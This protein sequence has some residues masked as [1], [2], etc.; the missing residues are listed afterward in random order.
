MLMFK[1]YWKDIPGFEN[2]YQASNLGR[3]KSLSKT[4]KTGRGY[5]RTVPDR[6]MKC[7]KLTP[8]GYMRVR[9]DKI[10]Y[11]L[12]RL[13]AITF[14]GAPLP[15]SDR[16]Q[17][18]HINGDKTDNRVENLEWVTNQENRDHAV[19][20]NLIAYDK[21]LPQTKLTRHEVELIRKYYFNK[22]FNQTELSKQFNVGQ[23]T[24]SRIVNFKSRVKFF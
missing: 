7:N 5:Y 15:N 10:T 12:H 11:Q 22:T 23:Q 3:I 19:K 18:N 1:E 2:R 24:I 16:I 8:K 21:K 17:V 6:I 13:I 9:I 4:Y 14:L 20:N